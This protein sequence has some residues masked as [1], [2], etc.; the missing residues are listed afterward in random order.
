MINFNRRRKKEFHSSSPQFKNSSR[1]FVSRNQSRLCRNLV[2]CVVHRCAIGDSPFERNR[3]PACKLAA[4]G[5]SSDLLRGG[6]GHEARIEDENR[7]LRTRL[8]WYRSCRS[9]EAAVNRDRVG[10]RSYL[11]CCPCPMNNGGNKTAVK[12]IFDSVR[13]WRT[14]SRTRVE[15]LFQFYSL[16]LSIHLF[17]LFSTRSPSRNRANVGR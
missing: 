1:S 17:F 8:K 3:Y 9:R 11:P 10:V 15:I 14:F 5:S 2:G 12:G 13:C 6:G 4:V 16:S 7:P